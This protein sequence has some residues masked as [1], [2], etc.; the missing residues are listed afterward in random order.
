MIEDVIDEVTEETEE[1]TITTDAEAEWALKKVLVAKRERERLLN[2]IDS[3]REELDRKQEKIE[4]QY[5]ANTGYLLSKLNAYLDKVERKKTKTQESYQLLS[6]KLVRKFSKAKL[7]PDE[8][9]L[10]EWC[11]QNAPECIKQ[12]EKPMWSE[13]KDKLVIVGNTVI[14]SETGECVPCVRVEETPAVFDVKGE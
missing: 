14:C 4:R 13:V 2:L 8:P 6:G 9:S 3:E 1:F 11:R 10:L 5:E 7:V 12:T